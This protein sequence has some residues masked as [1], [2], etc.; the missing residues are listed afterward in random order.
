M[1]LCVC[2][3][4]LILSE[5]QVDRAT[6]APSPTDEVCVVHCIGTDHK[7]GHYPEDTSKSVVKHSCSNVLQFLLGL[8]T[9]FA[10]R[11]SITTNLSLGGASAGTGTNDLSIED[12]IAAIPVEAP[13]DNSGK[14]LVVGDLGSE[15]QLAVDK[16]YLLVKDRRLCVGVT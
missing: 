3:R 14:F 15:L 7:S 2:S 1:Y 4:V 10:N 9:D 12:I 11:F 16:M 6:K 5:R 8:R 13:F